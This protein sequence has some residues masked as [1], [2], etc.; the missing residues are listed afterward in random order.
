MHRLLLVVTAA[1]ALVVAGCGKKSTSSAD[2]AAPAPASS[3]PR[4]VE[5]TAN[6]SMKFNVTR[7]EAAAG[8]ELRI[9]LRNVGSMP[10]EAMGH[11]WVLLKQG[12][13]AQAFVNAAVTAKA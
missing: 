2:A 6:D 9:V 11:N 1:A 7:I 12:S 13:D 8:E 3:G 5:I 10:K 4:V